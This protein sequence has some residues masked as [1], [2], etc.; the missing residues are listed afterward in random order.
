M[1]KEA[2]EC[3]PLRTS[4]VAVL[5]ARASA[6]SRE[7]AR[8]ALIGVSGFGGSGKSTLAEALHESLPGSVA[9]PGDE[10]LRDR[11]PQDRSDDWAAVDRERLLEQVL[12]PVRR[13]EAP[14]YQTYDRQARALGPRVRSPGSPVIVEGL[15]LFH[16]AIVQLFDLRIWVDVDLASATAQGKWRDKNVYL[17]AQT[18]LWDTVWMPTDE[19]FFARYRPDVAADVRYAPHQRRAPL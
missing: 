12:A 16:P 7:L 2:G 3:L 6:L 5:S 9:V 10:F 15:G 14:H 18:Q 8:A 19:A 11:P 13:G 1:T 17:N 4:D